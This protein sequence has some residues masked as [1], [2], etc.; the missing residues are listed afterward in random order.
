M[1]IHLIHDASKDIIWYPYKLSQVKF[2]WYFLIDFKYTIIAL[3]PHDDQC[4]YYWTEKMSLMHF[5][6][7]TISCICCNDFILSN[8][9]QSMKA[10]FAYSRFLWLCCNVNW[11][12]VEAWFHYMKSLLKFPLFCF[13][14]LLPIIVFKF[15]VTEVIFS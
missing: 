4:Q 14:L 9:P 12:V 3:V 6:V 15:R 8:Y 2:L 1:L 5:Y 11:E 13:V 7:L 10:Y